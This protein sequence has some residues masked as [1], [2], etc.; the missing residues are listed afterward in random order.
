MGLK[1]WDEGRW[2][3][4]SLVHTL[5]YRGIFLFTHLPLPHLLSPLKR[6]ALQR[7]TWLRIVAV[8]RLLNHR[9][10][11]FGGLGFDFWGLLYDNGETDCKRE[12]ETPIQGIYG[13]FWDWGSGYKYFLDLWL[14]V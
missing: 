13:N 8:R 3:K 11:G 6:M 12:L 4:G 14:N 9:L 10:L 7:C 5:L 2:V 1:R